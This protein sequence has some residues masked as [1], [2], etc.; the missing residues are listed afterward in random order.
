MPSQ[1]I[2]ARRPP[3]CRRQAVRYALATPWTLRALTLSS[4]QR[5]PSCTRTV[6]PTIP[7]RGSLP[8]VSATHAK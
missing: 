6:P 3:I 8:N 2:D 1:P 7:A 4:V 5:S